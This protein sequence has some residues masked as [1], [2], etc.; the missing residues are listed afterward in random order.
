MNEYQHL[1]NDYLVRNSMIAHNGFHFFSELEFNEILHKLVSFEQPDM[2][3]VMEDY[4]VALEHFEFDASRSNRKGMVGKREEAQREKRIEEATSDGSIHIEKAGYDI[5]LDDWKRNF[6]CC[7]DK[8]YSKIE[9]Y[10]RRVLEVTGYETKRILV[11]FFV[12]NQFS[13]YIKVK[14]CIGELPYVYTL[15]FAEKMK[16]SP[17]IDFILFGGYWGRKPQLIFLD[18]QG[19]EK[20]RDPVDLNE[21]RVLLLP[22]NNN[23]VI[24]YGKFEITED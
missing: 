5:S 10:K 16:E 7:F 6:D 11:G 14:N 9:T 21:D 18:R 8:H 22:L 19:I 20:I 17:N 1:I 13:P 24:A 3:A 4:I 2:Y 23:E 15:Q 12:E